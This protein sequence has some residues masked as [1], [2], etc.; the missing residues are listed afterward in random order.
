VRAVHR[1]PPANAMLPEFV[2]VRVNGLL[3][4]PV[5]QFLKSNAFGV[6]VA[7]LVTGTPFP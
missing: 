4:V 3:V 1:F 5:A 2:I 7:L 6:T